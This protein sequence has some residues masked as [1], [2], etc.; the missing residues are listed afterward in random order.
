MKVR[1]VRPYL[2][3]SEDIVAFTRQQINSIMT[4]IERKMPW[5]LFSRITD[6]I[7]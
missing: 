6:F 1:L 5:Q 4:N 3:N 7:E 2:M